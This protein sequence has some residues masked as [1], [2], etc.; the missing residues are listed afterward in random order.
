[1]AAIRKEKAVLD[2][3]KLEL[4]P[5]D[6]GAGVGE[7]VFLTEAPNNGGV[8]PRLKREKSQKIRKMLK[9][10]TSEIKVDQN[11]DRELVFSNCE[12]EN[13]QSRKSFDKYAHCKA[14]FNFNK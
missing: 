5:P 9:S 14:L 13:T 8:S 12:V 11:Q 2:Q 7:E 4:G 3:L 10:I 6:E 1:M